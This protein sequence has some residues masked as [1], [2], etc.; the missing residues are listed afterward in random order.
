LI[1]HCSGAE[2]LL[3]LDNRNK[4]MQD[5]ASEDELSHLENA[6]PELFLKIILL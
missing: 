1:S 2:L 3:V 6:F 4:H 5:I